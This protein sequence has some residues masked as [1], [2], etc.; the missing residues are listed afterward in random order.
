MT[1]KRIYGNG[2]DSIIGDIHH[3]A[4]SGVS[5]GDVRQMTGHCNEEDGAFPVSYVPVRSGIFN[6]YLFGP[7]FDAS[8]FIPAIEVLN[9]ASENDQVVI[10]LS[11]PG[12]NLDAT[13]TLLAAM[14]ECDAR[15]I[16]KATGG[17]HSAG[18]IILLHADEFTLSENFNCLIH[19]GSLGTGGTFSE[20]REAN[21]HRERYMESVMRSTYKGFLTDDEIEELLEGK[22]FWLDA[23]EFIR[24]YEA[25]NE[26]MRSQIAETQSQI[27]DVIAM[28]QGG[29]QEDPVK[30][31]RKR[32]SKKKSEKTTE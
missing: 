19:N 14:R 30:A 3:R 26:L 7:I 22:D 13:D 16:V 11:T 31:K 18:S 8:Q 6:I 1:F 17:V 12:G 4:G 23:D 32:R 24:R 21:K 10:H 28:L 20:W 27:A 25:R 29:V 2:V 5:A 9:A 15:I